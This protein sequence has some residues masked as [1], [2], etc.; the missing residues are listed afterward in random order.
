MGVIET[1]G[2]RR[3]EAH[4]L[5]TALDALSGGSG[6]TVEIVGEPGVGK[7]RLLAD[8]MDEARCRAIPVVHARCV[9]EERALPFH[10][11]AQILESIPLGDHRAGRA[12]AEDIE[13]LARAAAG[14]GP[15]PAVGES[16]RIAAAL[17]GLLGRAAGDGLLVVLDD[18]HWADPASADL[19]DRLVRRPTAGPVLLVIAQRP[20]QASQRLRGSLAHAC[21]LGA[22]TRIELGP[23]ALQEAANLLDLDPGDARLHELHRVSQGIP[24]Y[25]LTLAGIDPNEL[26]GDMPTQSTSLILG[27]I[28]TLDAAT[29]RI[30]TAAAILGD[31]GDAAALTV[32][33][34]AGHDEVQAALDCL[35]LHDVL[36]PVD[37]AGAYGFRHPVL[38]CLIYA[39][40]DP[41]WRLHAH[42][43]AVDLLSS[44]GGT[45][46]DR[47]VHVERSR[48]LGGPRDAQ[49]L[50]EAAEEVFPTDPGAA[51]QWL[52][53]A[54]RISPPGPARIDLT[55]FLARSLGQS[56]RL[57]ESRDLLHRVLR[58]I[59]MEEL[60]ARAQAVAFGSV[61][62]CLL[63]NFTEARAL[64]EDE[65][66]HAFTHPSPPPEAAALIIEH[67]IIGAFDGRLPSCG[68]VQMALR[69]ARRHADRTA[70]AG[71]LVLDGLCDAFRNR[72]HA[73]DS[74][75][76]CGGAI[77]RLSDGE[78]AAHPEYLGLLGWAETIVGAFQHA[79]RHFTRAMRIAQSTGQSHVFPALL[80]GLG[81]VY[82]QTGHLSD[83][84]RLAGEA[85]RLAQ[86]IRAEHLRGLALALEALCEVWGGTGLDEASALADRSVTLLR[87]GNH[88]WGVAASLTVATVAWLRGEA[89]RS[90]TVLLDAGGGP[91]LPGIPAFLRPQ[92]FLLGLLASLDAGEP[93]GPWADRVE[94]AVE[95]LASPAPRAYALL[96][97]AEVLRVGDD[98]AGAVARYRQAADLFGA[99]G[100][101]HCQARALMTI[102][103]HLSTLGHRR[104]AAATRILA[105][106]LAQRG[107][108][109]RLAP[110][111]AAVRAAVDLT[112]LTEREREIAEIAG[113]GL[114][115]R[116]IAERLSLSPRTV[117][118][119]LTRIYRKLNIR[120]RATL[121]RLMADLG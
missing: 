118:V 37:H 17:R 108:A 32:V 20:R 56:G 115:T 34:E 46:V 66:A 6:R 117:D 48:T 67:G 73:P 97:R 109:V 40:A 112:V 119:H 26:P 55:L 36:R 19:I 74:V 12:P 79:E 98:L 47:A 65:L 93:P 43:R 5:H 50:R 101:I 86:C 58:T 21:E 33:A 10:I 88:Y 99:A 25:L 113:S 107:G 23:L 111:P 18:F 64:L 42:R 103:P 22:A 61:V 95:G 9:V 91:H 72:P 85:D 29:L 54:L 63:G 110:P 38:R 2:L 3:A 1:T 41:T 7:T 89:R 16:Q 116:E 51:V 120:S 77:D 4:A 28:A 81:N 70:E 92:F 30:A 39:T 35:L 83:A 14:S 62:E 53:T 76:D 15:N 121:A 24:L 11:L 13:I 80:L 59:P 45:A 90:V 68:Q 94:K 84:R 44:R 87:Q 69:L 82:R 75:A 57:S 102:V 114:K 60:G 96:A 71:A 27:E 52:E 105:K 104:E 106:E 31:H 49:I 78:L 8:L 100:M